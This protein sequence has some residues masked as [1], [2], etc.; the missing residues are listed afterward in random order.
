MAADWTLA[1]EGKNGWGAVRLNSLLTVDMRDVALRGW[2]DVGGE[3]SVAPPECTEIRLCVTH[4]LGADWREGCGTRATTASPHGSS[5]VTI[6][7]RPRDSACG[8]RACDPSLRQ[9]SG[10]PWGAAPSHRTL[11]ELAGVSGTFNLR[12]FCVNAYSRGAAG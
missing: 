6:C 12:G 10:L 5:L 9:P 2:H 8:I 4:A 11:P 1:H 7:V 3:C